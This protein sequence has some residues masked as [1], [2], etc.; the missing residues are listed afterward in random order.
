MSLVNKK[1]AAIGLVI[2]FM[3]SAL[4]QAQIITPTQ[5]VQHV[6]DPELKGKTNPHWSEKYCTECHLEKPKDGEPITYK[7][8]GD[9]IQLC[10]SCH[11]T[12][13][14]RAEQHIVG[15]KLTVNQF[16]KRPPAE[17]LLQ[18][19]KL[20]CITCH[21]ARL[22]EKDNIS[23]KEN[24]P[25]FLRG[26]PYDAKITFEWNKS[27]KVDERYSQTRYVIC[28]ECHR[29]EP[30]LQWSPHQDQINRDGSV[31][32]E[33]CL[34]CHFEVPDRN[35]VDK[36]G[37]K[38]RRT[39]E[40]QCIN[41]HMGKSRLHP[42]RVTHY[43]NTSPDKIINQISFSIRR[44][45]LIIPMGI[46]AQGI[47]RLVCPSCHNPHQRGVLKN[48]ITEKGADVLP[49][50]LRLAGFAMCLACHGTA[51]GVPTPGTPF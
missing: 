18:D 35:A 34:F 14:F 39:I 20:T 23:T 36:A 7:F 29:E 44:V 1:T 17:F 49:G 8:E 10:K 9:F 16:I 48:P 32:D 42:I 15:V 21:D 11:D 24:N 33:I 19:E 13:L 5:E 41:C 12:A 28:L 25:M 45:G 40:D 6:P 22:Q 31:N 4:A 47:E 38:L 37:W 50:R 2:W 46:D 26:V 27:E 3:L 51:V 43:G 30:L